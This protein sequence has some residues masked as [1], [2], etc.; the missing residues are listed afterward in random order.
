VV[1]DSEG[2]SDGPW[3]HLPKNNSKRPC[4]SMIPPMSC[5]CQCTAA[6]GRWPNPA[7]RP[8]TVSSDEDEDEAFANPFT[9]VYV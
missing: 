7:P 6:V 3:Q 1:S 8:H 4:M 5:C 9:Q 2:D